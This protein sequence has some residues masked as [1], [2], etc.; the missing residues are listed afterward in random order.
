[1]LQNM[2][3]PKLNKFL[4]LDQ[5]PF[6]DNFVSVNESAEEFL[7]DINVFYC[8]E[9]MVA[10]TQHDVVVDD[11]YQYSVGSSQFAREFMD[12]LALN[13]KQNFLIRMTLSQGF[14]K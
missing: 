4:T 6:T 12:I 3:N 5:M 11:Y 10:Q 13:I 14:S 1:M 9:C 7:N 8:P 2:L